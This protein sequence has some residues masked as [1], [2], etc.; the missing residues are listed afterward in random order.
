[1]TD[2]LAAGAAGAVTGGLP[3]T[4]WALATGADPRE[5]T[6]AAGSMLLPHEERASRLFVAAVPVHL[7]FSLGWAVV[8]APVLPRRQE[9]AGGAVAG[10]A[11]AAL[12]L[13]VGRRVFPRVRAL[14]LLP[15]VADHVAYGATVGFTLARR[16][17]SPGGR[18]RAAVA[19]LTARSASR[20]GLHRSRLS[21]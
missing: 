1:M 5:A 3:S 17:R 13:A 10:L 7:A 21:P 12:D 16:R 19:R 9:V 15:Q 11:I 20:R 4:L 6:L 18:R 8:L 2:A 14:P